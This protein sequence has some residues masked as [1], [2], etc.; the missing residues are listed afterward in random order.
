V[1][2]PHHVHLTQ[3]VI[4]AARHRNAGGLHLARRFGR[5]SKHPVAF[6]DSDLDA[7]VADHVGHADE[8]YIILYHNRIGDALA[9]DTITVDGNS[10]L[11]HFCLL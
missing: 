3:Q 6:L 4:E 10:N 7:P 1:W 8:L 9:D 5:R 2:H 11:G